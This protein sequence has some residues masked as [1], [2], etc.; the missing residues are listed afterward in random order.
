[1][2][3]TMVSDQD[4]EDALALDRWNFLLAVSMI[5]VGLFLY[6]RWGA[7]GVFFV[8]IG[9]YGLWDGFKIRVKQTIR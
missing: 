6:P 8:G 5:V 7:A 1:M 3:V 9:L 2:G 4:L